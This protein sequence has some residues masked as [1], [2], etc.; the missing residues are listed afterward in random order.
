MK[1]SFK[2]ED[3]QTAE[4]REHC[5]EVLKEELDSNCSDSNSIWFLTALTNELNMKQKSNKPDAEYTD[6]PSQKLQFLLPNMKRN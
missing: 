3:L 4:T 5:V 6:R 2:H 1:M